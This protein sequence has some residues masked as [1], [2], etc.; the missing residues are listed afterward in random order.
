MVS[1]NFG[2]ERSNSAGIGMTMSWMTG[3]TTVY[4]MI[5]PPLGR[6]LTPMMWSATMVTTSPS[7]APPTSVTPSTSTG[8]SR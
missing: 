3:S 6:T 2:R 8:S 5:G 1:P 7:T 4:P